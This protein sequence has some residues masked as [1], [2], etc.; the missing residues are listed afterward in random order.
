MHLIGTVQATLCLLQ[1]WLMSQKIH[2]VKS[3][4][5]EGIRD[6]NPRDVMKKYTGH[7]YT[8]HSTGVADGKEGIIEFFNDF[9]IRNPMCEIDIAR[10]FEEGHHGFF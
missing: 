9:L 7:C 4:Y 8:R 10:I 3:L 1:S 6:G 2:N 5:F